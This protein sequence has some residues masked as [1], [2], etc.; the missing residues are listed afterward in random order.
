MNP[1]K[2]LR[3]HKQASFFAALLLMTIPSAGLFIA[4]DN[5]AVQ[6]IWVGFSL[7]IFGN[8]IALLVK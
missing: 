7:I 5:A 3:S 4:A 8:F 2:W 1:L 6:W